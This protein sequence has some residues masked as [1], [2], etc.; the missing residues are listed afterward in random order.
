[1]LYV[2]STNSLYLYNDAGNSITG[3]LTPGGPGSLSNS[4]CTLSG[5]G[6]SVSGSGN[7]LTLNLAESFTLNFQG[8]K[9]IYGAVTDNAMLTSGWQNLGTFMVRFLL[10]IQDSL[11][12]RRGNLRRAY[13]SR[14]PRVT[15]MAALVLR[16]HG[17]ANSS[18]PLPS[19]NL[20]Q[21]NTWPLSLIAPPF[22]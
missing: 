10:V 20:A 16:D 17:V 3:P 21:K 4:Q 7:T 12:N 8:V 18:T 9:T 2:R 6:S 15:W 1:M 19:V 11:P 13:T 5:P 14:H 22:M